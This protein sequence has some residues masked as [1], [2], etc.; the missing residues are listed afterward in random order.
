M[1]LHLYIPPS[2]A[3]PLSCLKGLITGE[4]LRYKKQ[5]NNEGF[6]NITTSFLE[7]MVARGHKLEDLIPLVH[8]AAATIDKKNFHL[9]SH[10]C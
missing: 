9:L 6:I 4:L 1:N 10:K 3:H 5:N 2:S 7:W 8:E